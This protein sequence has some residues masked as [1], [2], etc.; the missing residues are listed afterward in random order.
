MARRNYEEIEQLKK[1]LNVARLWS[2]SRI[3]TYI[4]CSYSYFLKYIKKE[5]ER[6]TSIYS[7]LGTAFHDIL[8]K[9]YNHKISY[10]EMLDEANA[11][12]LNIE[13]NTDLRFDKS[14]KDKNENIKNKYFECI[15]H[16]FENHKSVDFKVLTEKEIII[17][18]GNH[19]FQGYIDAI[20]KEKDTYII[21]DYKSSTIYTGEKID[22]ESKQLR[23]YA[24]G[25]MQKG[26]PIDKIK[27]QWNFLKYCSVSFLQ[28]NGKSKTMYCE[29][30][31]WI[32]KMSNQIRI[33]LNDLKTY[34]EEEINSLIEKSINLNDA[35]LLP[36]DVINKFTITDCYVDIPLSVEIINDLTNELNE[37]VIEIYT[38]EKEYEDTKDESIWYKTVTDKCSY[39]CFNLCGFTASQCSCYKEFLDNIK[40]FKKDNSSSMS[41]GTDD[42]MRDL[43]LI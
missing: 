21:T 24:L 25:L 31:S 28:K 42:W 7:L 8:E 30:N 43:G 33:A 18:I 9:Y 36:N 17:K 6:E 2:F 35:S 22:K 3:N 37:K 40:M 4:T 34:S 19:Y 39:F 14:D 15:R 27:C 10:E 26:I 11:V 38:K 20:H 1:D 29:R 5:K 13:L 12:M 41:D 32:A 16:F 23:L